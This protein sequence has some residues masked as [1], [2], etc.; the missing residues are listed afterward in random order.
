MTMP[1]TGKELFYAKIVGF[2]DQRVLASYRSE[3]DKYVL[4][5]DNFEGHLRIAYSDEALSLPD[6]IDIRFGYR[7][8]VNGDL[9]LAVYLP[10]LVEKSSTH[11]QRWAAYSLNTSVLMT[12]PDGRFEMW[13][14]RYLEGS[15]DIENGPRFH[16][17]D[18]IELINALCL[19]KVGQ[20]LFKYKDNPALNFP[21]V[22][23]TH[24]YQDAHR[25]LYGYILDGLEMETIKRIAVSQGFVVDKSAARTVKA[26]KNA[27]PSL[28]STSVLWHVLEKV[29]N[30]RGN[31]GHGVR[32]SAQRF[33][34][35]EEFTSDLEK[36]VT[37][38]KELLVTLESVFRMESE[39][40]RT[41][42]EAKKWLPQ[43]EKP[44]MAHFSIN[45]IRDIV[46]KT[47]ERAEFG[48]RQH[49]D[50]L[51]QSEAIILHFT[52]G[53]T[54]GVDTGSNA[55]NVADEYE[56]LQPEDFHTDFVL[57]WVPAPQ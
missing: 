50:G 16:L 49:I 41:R 39:R 33:S 34:A 26:L 40:A 14:A 4:E 43:I 19:E 3:P 20:T 12:E 56:G 47:V 17:T 11:V 52:D 37:G 21:S 53:S 15:W 2:F 23:N 24:A 57:S 32:P 45:K 25:E 54:L 18:T 31:A 30:E 9:A 36:S 46:G 51:H 27:L 1:P 7:T 38:L 29:S 28:P 42:Q 35:F 48:F 6:S 22:Q 10:D 13:K 5:T 44:S 8:C 55:T